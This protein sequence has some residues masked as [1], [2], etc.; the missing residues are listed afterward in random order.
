[1][2]NIIISESNLKSHLICIVLTDVMCL[3]DQITQRLFNL[4]NV[5]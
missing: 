5:N 1:M 3:C 2:N 4:G